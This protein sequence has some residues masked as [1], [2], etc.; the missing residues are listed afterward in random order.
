MIQASML[1]SWISPLRNDFLFNKALHSWHLFL[2][3]LFWSIG[4]SILTRWCGPC[5]MIGPVFDEYSKSYL[6]VNF[7]KVD[8]DE[9]E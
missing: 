5:Q 3:I 7:V 8:V 2:L 1:Q 9:L 4:I 6:R